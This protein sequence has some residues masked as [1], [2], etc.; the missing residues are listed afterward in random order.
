MGFYAFWPFSLTRVF[1]VRCF[2]VSID[3]NTDPLRQYLR[4][5]LKVYSSPTQRL[6]MLLSSVYRVR[7][8]PPSYLER[9]SFMQDRKSS[10]T[11]PGRSLLHNM[12][13]AGFKGRLQTIN[14][15]E[16]VRLLSLF[17]DPYTMAVLKGSPRCGG[18]WCHTEKVSFFSLVLVKSNRKLQPFW[19]DPPPWTP[20]YC[21]TGACRAWPCR[22]GG[23]SQALNWSFY[24][25]N[26]LLQNTDSFK[27]VHCQCINW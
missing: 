24:W 17:L 20:W 22:C 11:R 14:F 4:Q 10:K 13:R 26:A 12:W 9:I 16:E 25:L 18:D 27:S 7:K 5:N 3:W 2:P 6:P 15:S 19:K 21:K 1:K 23:Q 8:K